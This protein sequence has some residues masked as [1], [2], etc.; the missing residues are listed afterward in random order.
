MPP[1]LPQ[2][3]NGDPRPA[4]RIKVLMVIFIT[5]FVIYGLK[6]F[7]M[8]I[9]NGEIYVSAAQKIARRATTIPAQRGEIYDRSF[10]QPLAMNVDSFAVSITP[11]DA[12]ES[13]LP[14]IIGQVAAILGVNREVID[15]KIPPRYYTLYQPVEIAVNVPFETVAALAEHKDSLPGVTWQSKPLR[16]YVDPGSLSHILGYVGNITQDPL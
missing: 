5:V 16:Q 6:L 9:L 8:Q 14:D 2:S 11:A 15:Y 7:N 13:E 10:T 3:N 4:G 12:P 1:S